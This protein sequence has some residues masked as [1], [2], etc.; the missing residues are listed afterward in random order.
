MKCQKKA[1]GTFSVPSPLI[2]PLGKRNNYKILKCKYVRGKMEKGRELENQYTSKWC[3]LKGWHHLLL[4]NSR[5]LYI[6][7]DDYL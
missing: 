3:W 4:F 6:T 5:R 2:P 7:A 1:N